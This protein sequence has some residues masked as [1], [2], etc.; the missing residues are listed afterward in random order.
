MLHLVKLVN[1]NEVAIGPINM[2]T[3]KL[4]IFL[5][6]TSCAHGLQVISVAKSDNQPEMTQ[7]EATKACSI[8]L[9]WEIKIK[10][11]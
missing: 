8:W 9:S 7:Q 5:T 6:Q 11:L 1:V 4:S 2:Q 10:S 3:C